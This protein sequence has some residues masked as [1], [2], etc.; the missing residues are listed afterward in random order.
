M[1]DTPDT[2][3]CQGDTLTIHFELKLEDGTLVDSTREDAEPMSLTLGEGVLI[4]GLEEVMLGMA[5][6][7][8]RQVNMEP[9]E[10]FGYPEPDRL[11][12]ME[13]TEFDP[14]VELEVGMIVGFETPAGDET[15][16]TIRE[17]GDDWVMVDFNHPLAGH[18]VV[19]EVEVLDINPRT[20]N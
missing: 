5:V 16:G 2:L 4:E 17:L 15:P 12:K 3:V 14:D 10:A 9:R 1:T 18:N 13:R 11:Y 19:F 8:T 20:L 6:G 7:E